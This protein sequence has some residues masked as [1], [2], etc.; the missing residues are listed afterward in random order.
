M[1]LRARRALI[2][3]A[4]SGLGRAIAQAWAAEGAR[5]LCA[6]ID[7]D[8]AHETASLIGA[9]GAATVLDVRSDAQIDAAVDLCCERFGGIDLVLNAAGILR[10]QPILETTRESFATTLDVNLLGLF[11]VSRAAAR[12]MVS[13][14]TGGAIINVASIAGRHG[15]FAALQYSASK[16]AVISVTQSMAQEL[17]AH[18]IN[19][20]A[21]APG[22]MQTGMWQEIQRQYAGGPLG[23]DAAEIDAN[24]ASTVAAGRLG[25]PDD[26]S[27]TAVFLASEDARYIVGQTLNVDGGVEYN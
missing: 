10:Y 6:D 4:G 11:M 17:V 20:N 13:Q 8:T 3:G 7:G 12:R 15:N 9:A 23:A 27:G 25:V 5:V 19:V 2:T 1:K 24:V 16:A 14:G 21:I 18:R 22:Y 26:L